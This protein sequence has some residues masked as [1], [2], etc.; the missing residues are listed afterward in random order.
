MLDSAGHLNTIGDNSNR[1]SYERVVW[2]SFWGNLGLAIL[3]MCVGILGYSILL[4]ADGLHSS[5]NAIMSVTLLMG[6]RAAEKPEDMKHP[7]GYQKAQ[8]I[9]LGVAGLI[10]LAAGSYLFMIGLRRTGWAGIIQPHPIA[11]LVV[12]VSILGNELMYRYGSHAGREF[13]SMLLSSNALN[14]RI[15]TC[16]SIV[17]LLSLLAAMAR[18]WQLEQIGTIIVAIIIISA[19]VMILQRAYKSLMGAALPA[20]TTDRIRRI[21]E[22]VSGVKTVSTVNTQLSGENISV[23]LEIGLDANIN[24]GKANIVANNVKEELFQRLKKVRE[25][26][27]RFNIV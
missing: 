15:N 10:I 6:L 20:E 13:D 18:F 16:S 1:N 8:S 3:K 11:I 7:Y 19:S 22:S 5:A 14:N 23:D 9:F 25:V 26:R 12:I 27:V 2:I 21:A 17:V 4:F 24:A